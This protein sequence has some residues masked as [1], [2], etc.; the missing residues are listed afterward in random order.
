MFSQAVAALKNAEAILLYDFVDREGE[1]HLIFF[2]KYATPIAVRELRVQAG[3]PLSVYVSWDAAEKLG[4]QTYSDF[5]KSWCDDAVYAG[6]VESSSKVDPRF[7][8]TLDFRENKTGC[9]HVETS[10]AILE[11]VKLIEMGRFDQF[12]HLFRSPG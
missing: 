4:L 3:A 9:S 2:A 6:L 11:L 1:T 8:I 12:P 5:V 7:S 10:R